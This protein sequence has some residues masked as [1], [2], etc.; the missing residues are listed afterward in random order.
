[1]D[2]AKACLKDNSPFGVCLIREGREVGHGAAW[3]A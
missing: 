3:R 1:M 2:M